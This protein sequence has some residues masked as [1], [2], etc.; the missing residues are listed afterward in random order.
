MTN[1]KTLLPPITPLT[2][3]DKPESALFYVLHESSQWKH[4][5][6]ADGIAFLVDSLGILVTAAHVVWFAGK[7][8]G[9]TVRVF[10]LSPSIP[11]YATATILHR[12]WRG[13]LPGTNGEIPL[14]PGRSD[15]LDERPDV[16]KE[17]LALLQLNPETIEF[18]SSR[19]GH[20]EPLE[21][22][23]SRLRVMP[24]GVPGYK[25][26]E[27]AHFKMWC[28]NRHFKAP[29]MVAVNGTFRTH[30]RALHSAFQ[31]AASEVKHGFSGSPVW[32]ETR[33]LA[34]GFV[35]SGTSKQLS[36]AARCT[37]ARVIHEYAA[38]PLTWDV[39]LGKV[40]RFANGL[41]TDAMGDRY[42]A[43]SPTS[44]IFIEPNARP[45]RRNLDMSLTDERE[46]G[47][48]ALQLIKQV[49]TAAPMVCLFGGPGAGKSTL[50]KKF[51]VEM[52]ND[53]TLLKQGPCI[54]LIFDARDIPRKFDLDV[55]F[56]LSPS[57][58]KS[59]P[60]TCAL[61]DALMRN[62]VRVVLLID[63]LD[64]IEERR[65]AQILAQCQGLLF[66]TTSLLRVLLTS[67]PS[68]SLFNQANNKT[69]S[70]TLIEILPFD[71]A[72]IDAYVKQT[73]PRPEEGQ[74]FCDALRRVAWHRTAL[75][76][77]L[78]MAS[79]IFG[80][81]N[82]LPARE[83]DLPFEY[84][85]L[86]VS[87]SASDAVTQKDSG[88]EQEA[89]TEI[90]RPNVA[91]ILQVLALLRFQH[92]EQTLAQTVESMSV[93]SK[94]EPF[95][96]VLHHPE[97]CIDYIRGELIPKVGLVTIRSRADGEIL[98]W[99]HSTFVDVLAAEARLSM[100]GKDP[101][102]VGKLVERESSGSGRQFTL[103]QLSAL[104]RAGW[105]EQVA[106][107][108]RKA[109][110][111]PFSDRKEGMFA[112]R[113]LATGVELTLD[114]KQRL[115]C[116]LIRIALSPKPDFMFCDE[117]FTDGAALPQARDI[118]QRESIRADVIAALWMRLRL[119]DPRRR[120]QKRPLVVTH[121]E[122]AL[123]DLLHLWD[124]WLD[125][126]LELAHPDSVAGAEQPMLR[127][128]SMNPSVAL[129]SDD[130]AIVHRGGFEVMHK[131]G[132][133]STYEIP[134]REF[135]EGIVAMAKE[136]PNNVPPSH[137]VSLYLKV[138]SRVLDNKHS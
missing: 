114:L 100:A 120:G 19:G 6:P 4:G 88:L 17:D 90:Y 131:D 132:T 51:A 68:D 73:M 116:L 76:L 69:R 65:A 118:L 85:N 128:Q 58:E 49:A 35:R 72:Q 107:R 23:I 82:M 74:R 50:L 60:R 87:R 80:A 3:E 137:V 24:L 43:S 75:P 30:E 93:L 78:K 83:A 10:C 48:P 103:T 119:R 47:A 8:P 98:V 110:E 117:V 45:V 101:A 134:A 84:V 32:D 29:R 124:E 66:G 96:E 2:A 54:P 26:M 21:V 108:V 36:S 129:G 71:S 31:I 1:K 81:E 123:L 39:D 111:A 135:L 14:L 62:D 126:G 33:R 115:I 79:A 138:V 112:L 56:T 95:R 44:S 86:I 22:L 27:N 40:V 122:A 67:R 37:D 133:V 99:E 52:L 94:A 53:P 113:A 91:R 20:T 46:D 25:S 34:V 121:S 28:V 38:L 89:W 42:A 59:L 102:A 136:L 16:L 127:S 64:E 70:L 5:E 105:R 130:Q 9:S 41:A 63:G 106:Q 125:Q 12:G 15:L 61:S 55:L 11:I 7:F 92:G 104:D 18:D 77:Q 109:M 13:P 97:E 57:K